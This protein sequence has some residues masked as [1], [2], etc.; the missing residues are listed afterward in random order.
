MLG[1]G[2][3]LSTPLEKPPRGSAAHLWFRRSQRAGGGARETSAPKTNR[4]GKT[5]CSTCRR[6]ERGRADG[7][8]PRH[9]RDPGPVPF[10]AI[11]NARRWKASAAGTHPSP[12]IYLASGKRFSQ[13]SPATGL[14]DAQG[15]WWKQETNGS[16]GGIRDTAARGTPKPPPRI[17]HS[18]RGF[19]SCLAPPRRL[20]HHL[21]ESSRP[22]EGAG[23]G[24]R[25]LR[26]CRKPG[27]RA[28]SLWERKAPLVLHLL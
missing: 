22:W 14:G 4:P 19:S 7:V 16:R 21:H 25:R 23:T 11:T 9:R 15:V 13:P 3:A 12:L 5:G 17:L 24:G 6:R 28:S 26:G 10:S 27:E 1:A 20:G 8:T 18:L 2:R